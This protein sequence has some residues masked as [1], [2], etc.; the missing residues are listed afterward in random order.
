M[1][2]DA[3]CTHQNE[4]DKHDG[5]YLPKPREAPGGSSCDVAGDVPQNIDLEGEC[6]YREKEKLRPLSSRWQASVFTRG[7]G[8]VRESTH[9]ERAP[10]VAIDEK[11]HCHPFLRVKKMRMKLDAVLRK[12]IRVSAFSPAVE[13]LCTTALSKCPP[14]RLYRDWFRNVLGHDRRL[15]C[16]LNQNPDSTGVLHRAIVD[17]DFQSV[18]D[19][20][21]F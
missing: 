18:P 15:A 13:A 12:F 9:Y 17:S 4:G 6:R 7:T 19:V 11:V 10:H 16:I 1:R 21:G 5:Y 14:G 2:D 20:P 8:L 3:E